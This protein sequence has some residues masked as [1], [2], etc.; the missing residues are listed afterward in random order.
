MTASKR[1]AEQQYAEAKL[2]IDVLQGDKALL[3]QRMADMRAG[4]VSSAAA[5][6][7]SRGGGA[8]AAGGSRRSGSGDDAPAYA[9]DA[10]Y[11]RLSKVAKECA[12]MVAALSED[13][14]AVSKR[15]AALTTC[16]IEAS[17]ADVQMVQVVE[18]MR[19]DKDGRQRLE[20][21]S[22]ENERLNGLVAEATQQM[23]TF[24][25]VITQMQSADMESA[26]RLYDSV[27]G[28]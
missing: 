15:L 19:G 4:G 12:A 13:H 23:D 11:A 1:K 25:A 20:E 24:N 14:N 3:Q 16:L 17:R 9:V 22:L 2:T 6:G 21:L 10:D 28:T 18:A 26:Q 5:A 7:L 27:S 8:E